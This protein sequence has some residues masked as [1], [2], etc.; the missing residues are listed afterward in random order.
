VAHCLSPLARDPSAPLALVNVRTGL[1]VATRLIAAFDSAS[2]RQG[3]IGRSG[4]LSG[5]ALILAPCASIHTAFMR[6][7]LDVLFLDRAGTVLKAASDVQPWR[8]RMAWRAFAVVELTAGVLVVSD[9]RTGDTVEL[10][11]I[12]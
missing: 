1:P 3:L 11:T 10:R 4:L 7:P 6:F 8:V 12:V 9:T 2:R 5:D